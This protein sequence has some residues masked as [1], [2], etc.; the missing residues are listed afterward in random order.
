MDPEDPASL[1]QPMPSFRFVNPSNRLQNPKLQ[2]PK[3]E[4]PKLSDSEPR[5][6]VNP[7]PEQFENS[8]A[9]KPK[10]L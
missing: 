6:S 3:P 9:P 8:N 1:P 5:A 4:A 10:F 7:G 2:N